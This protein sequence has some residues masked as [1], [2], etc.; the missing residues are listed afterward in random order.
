MIKKVDA[1]NNETALANVKFNLYDSNKTL[2]K[3]A[4]TNVSGEIYFTNVPDGTYYLE[5]ILPDTYQA[6]SKWT[7]IVVKDGE[8]TFT[9]KDTSIN[10]DNDTSKLFELFASVMRIFDNPTKEII[11]TAEKPEG[12]DSKNSTSYTIKNYKNP[13]VK[14]YKYGIKENT[15]DKYDTEVLGNV[16]FVLQRLENNKWIEVSR[17]KSKDFTGEVKF[18]NLAEGEYRILEPEAPTGYRQ[19]W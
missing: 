16:E 13:D 11:M 12:F 14:L 15:V 4:E 19:P 6:Q 10:E 5:E 1:S 3:T 9:H 2:I 7:T 8:I 17:A 18:E